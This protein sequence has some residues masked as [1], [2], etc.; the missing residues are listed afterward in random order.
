[1]EGEEEASQHAVET[2]AGESSEMG[3][4]HIG[5]RKRARKFS[6]E[7]NAS[8]LQE[9]ELRWG[10]LTQGVRGKPT[11]KAYQK[12][13]TEIAEVVSSATNEVREGNQC[14][15]RRNDLVGSAR[16]K[17][18]TMRTVQK[19][20]G[21]GPPVPSDITEMEERVLAFV[22]KH[23]RTAMNAPADPEV[24]PPQPAARPQARPQ[25][26]EGGGAG[27]DSPDDPTSG[28]EELRFLPVNL[29]GLFSTDES[30]EFKESALPGSRS[31]STARPSSG[32]PVIP[33]STLEVPA[34]S[35]SPQGTPFVPRTAPTPP[36]PCG[37]G[38][39]VPRAPH[40]SREKIHL[41]RRTVDIG[42]QLIEAFGGI[43]RQ[44]A[45]MTEYILWMAESLDAIARSTAG[46]GLPVVP[47]HGT[48][49]LGSVPSLLTTDESKE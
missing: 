16:K 25:R 32:S 26:P 41:S 1:M 37:C 42:D 34:P 13:W 36:R 23:T 12:I 29:L 6:D 47:E 21:G 20:T 11:P 49:P 5:G 46:T 3:E 15:K 39:S 30:A 2:D 17:L 19:R 9:V 31:H 4:E 44:L 24:M 7:A 33:A 10:D 43:S 35:T 28:A 38:R 40:E 8:L 45:T 48:P 18:S 27:T 22:G 14:H